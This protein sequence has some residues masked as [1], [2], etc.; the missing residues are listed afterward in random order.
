MIKLADIA[1]KLD[2]DISVVSRALNPNPDKNAVVKKETAELIRRTAKEM[3][4]VPNRQAAFLGKGKGATIFCY[5]PDV[6]TRLIND[7]MF[8][9]TEAASKENFPI[10][11]F[12]GKNSQDFDDFLVHGNRIPHTGLI[13][14]PPSKMSGKMLEAFKTYYEKCGNI[15]FL[16]TFSNAVPSDI[17]FDTI[18]TLNID[19]YHGGVLAAE[20]LL[21]NGCDEFIIVGETTQAQIFDM[22]NNGFIDYLASKNIKCIRITPA[23]MDK[24]E[25]KSDKKYGFFANSDYIAL[26]MYPFFA[27]KNMEIGKNIKLIGFDDIFYSRISKPSLTTVHQP[28]RIEG[29]VAVRKMINMV[30]GKKEDSE[31]LKPFLMVRES[32]GGNRPD[33]EHPEKEKIVRN[34]GETL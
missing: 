19:E 3:G 25:I 26:N 29:H 32:T 21:L 24:F 4:Y 14:F 23:E 2:L 20:H 10:N 30:F 18:P 22:R 27:R 33:P 6:S 9:I 16:N 13:T 34:P 31:T 8:G 5:L 11:F 15:L 17:I 28:T 12:L 7:L 1:R